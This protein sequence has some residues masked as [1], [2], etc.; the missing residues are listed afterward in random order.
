MGHGKVN[1]KIFQ[2]K[3][4]ERIRM[5]RLNLRCLEGAE[6]DLREMNLKDGDNGSGRMGAYT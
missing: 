3:Q 4:E 5:G 1:K 6:K 2:S